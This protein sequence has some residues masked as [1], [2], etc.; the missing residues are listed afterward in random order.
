MKM[1]GGLSPQTNAFLEC[2]W[3]EYLLETLNPVASCL[4]KRRTPDRAVISASACF[5]LGE[6]NCPRLAVQKKK[7]SSWLAWSRT[8]STYQKDVPQPRPIPRLRLT[9]SHQ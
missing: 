2:S 6:N 7:Q 3:N 9:G 8:T 1:P 4:A 5:G